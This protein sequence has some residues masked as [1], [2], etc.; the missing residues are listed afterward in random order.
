MNM[1]FV[2]SRYNPRAK[3]INS[4]HTVS[5]LPSVRKNYYQTPVVKPQPVQV[6]A[7]PQNNPNKIRWGPP[8]WFLFHTLAHKIKDEHFSKIKTEL[9]NNIIIICMNLPCP[10]CSEHA[11]QY[12]KK[13]N[14]GAIHTKDD[15]KNFLF[16]FHNDVNVR[17]GAPLFEYNDLN[18]KYNSAVTI[19]IVQNF[20]VFFKDKTF[21][22]TAIANSMHR[23][24]I[25]NSLKEWFHKNIQCFDP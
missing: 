5:M 22:V 21:N 8:T 4:Q 10:K 1:Q 20:F 11:T 23:E 2:N 6:Q 25:T 7:V 3:E 19:N 15:F 13:I 17:T 14:V 9:L 18:N 12:M 24:R 16:K